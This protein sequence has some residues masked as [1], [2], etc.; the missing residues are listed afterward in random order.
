MGRA[1][2][3]TTRRD[4]GAAAVEFALLFPLFLAIVFGIINFGF[5]FNQ[6][7]NLTQTAREAS[8]YGATLSLAASGTGSPPNGTIDTW[9]SKV[10][11]VA[12]S[13]GGE[14]VAASRSGRYVCVAYVSAT[15]T[16]S[17]TIGSGAP[18]SSAP[19][20]PDGRTDTRVQVVVRSDTVLDVLLFGGSI[21]VGSQSATHYEAAT[22]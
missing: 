16:K 10:Q 1:R 5:A 7:I 17:L 20:F 14:D 18:A 11:S 6:K 22:T 12:L 9:L 4:S 13:A 3:T 21:T 8:R 19:C 15:Q 2:L